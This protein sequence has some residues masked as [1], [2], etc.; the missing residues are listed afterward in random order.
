MSYPSAPIPNYPD[1]YRIV[2]RNTQNGSD[3][4]KTQANFCDFQLQINNQGSGIPQRSYNFLLSSQD[5]LYFDWPV[6]SFLVMWKAEWVN[7]W[8][9]G[10][11]DG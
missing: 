9:D 4:I 11:V 5:S 1:I 2:V 10:W 3:S 6:D 7:G 8:M